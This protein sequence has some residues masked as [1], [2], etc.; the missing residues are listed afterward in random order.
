[1]V[2]D[3]EGKEQVCYDMYINQKKPMEEIMEYFRVE[4]DFTPRYVVTYRSMPPEFLLR[5]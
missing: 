3:W 5:M 2:Y 1:M 4:E